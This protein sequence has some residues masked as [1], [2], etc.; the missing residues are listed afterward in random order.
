MKNFIRKVAFG[1]SPNEEVPS[2]PL[3]WATEQIKNVPEL[4]GKVKYIQKKN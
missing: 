3:N 4:S 2:D 1:L